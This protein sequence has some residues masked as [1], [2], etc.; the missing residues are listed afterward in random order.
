[1]T[2]LERT[3][4]SDVIRRFGDQPLVVSPD[5]ARPNLTRRNGYLPMLLDFTHEDQEAR[6]LRSLSDPAAARDLIYFS[7]LEMASK[8]EAVLILG[9]AGAG[10]TS[11]ALDLALNL[12]GDKIGDPDFN[13]DRLSRDIVR[14]EQGL[15]KP[16][17]WDGPIATPIYL[18][19]DG[20]STLASLLERLAPE[21]MALLTAPD[22]GP[23]LIIL[24]GA[25]RLAVE[26]PTVL[27]ELADL[28]ERVSK[29]RLLVTGRPDVCAAWSLPDCFATYAL[30]PLLEAQRVQYQT[31]RGPSGP[32]PFWP[33]RPDLFLMAVSAGGDPAPEHRLLDHWIGRAL[34]KKADRDRLAAWAFGWTEAGAGEGPLDQDLS[35]A[36]R[37]ADAT[38]LLTTTLAP[39]LT[40]AH[41]QSLPYETLFRL[42][43]SAPGRW[44]ES[45]RI[46]AQRLSS[47]EESVAPLIS[48]LLDASR[49][50]KSI[51]ALLSADILHDGRGSD[52]A[53]WP[54]VR[55]ELA[56]AIERSDLSIGLRVAVGRHLARQGDP[57]D[58]EA[59]VALPS[60]LVAIGS[61]NHI[62]STPEHQVRVDALRMGRFPITNGLY[63]R[64]I[65]ETG[66]LWRSPDG[67][68]TDRSNSP[69]ADLTWRDARAFCEWLT[70]LW[71]RQGRIRKG[72]MVRL[73]TEPEW[74]YAAR[75]GASLGDEAV[76]PA[77]L[78]Y[79]WGGPWAPDRANSAEAG[80]NT[81]CAV[82][83][84]PK[85]R[86]TTGL[87]DLTG[88]VW[89]WTTTLWGTD[90]T[91]PSFPYPYLHD[92]REWEEAGPAV[93][94]VLRGGCFSSPKFKA[95]S[96]YR[97]SLE[98]DGFWR[99]NGFR[100]AVSE[101]R[102][103]R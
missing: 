11:F 1:M 33:R 38:P 101:G 32:L 90:M 73:P 47:G 15:C 29:V 53:P 82:G 95:S 20:P 56:A 4:C 25:E 54:Q 65:A 7:A 41:L 18:P 26:G 49:A 103:R 42:F 62:N 96:T 83:L 97:G 59:L 21:A 91:T 84:F 88:Q 50:G 23:V 72:E 55:S 76:D 60:A 19:A 80:L 94:R 78:I 13:V 92:G 87:D 71:R 64:F 2:D 86:S 89:E 30:L 69:A 99:G 75:G 57:R 27:A 93:R 37:G 28:A 43:S 22:R 48:L 5:D 98:P 8:H 31:A 51:G 102:H 46:L 81:V 12:A 24:D 58:L 14:N 34:P 61:V 3:L 39:F 40:A 100:V 77:A 35:G 66:R 6:G 74:E 9:T 68:Q 16:E 79:P 44:T 85:G 67:A 10:K 52:P 17:R 36:L 70:P 63:R 45:F